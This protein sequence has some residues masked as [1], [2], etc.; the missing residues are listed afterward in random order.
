MARGVLG[1]QIGAL[2]DEVAKEVVTPEG[3]N[4]HRQR[5]DARGLRR[6]FRLGRD[7]LI[8]D[9]R[10]RVFDRPVK[11]RLQHSVNDLHVRAL[12][13]QHRRRARPI[14]DDRAHQRRL[15][16]RVGRIDIHALGGQQ[17]REHF[18]TP[19]L[20]GDMHHRLAGGVHAFHIR[21]VLEQ[22]FED[23]VAESRDRADRKRVPA[24]RLAVHVRLAREQH[25]HHVDAAIVRRHLERRARRAVERLHIRA[26]VEQHLDDLRPAVDHRLVQGGVALRILQIH[27][28][29]VLNQKLRAVGA[30]VNNHVVDRRVGRALGV[31]VRLGC[32]Q[33]LGRV[34]LA[35]IH[36]VLKRRVRRGIQRIHFRAL[37]RQV[38]DHV[39]PAIKRRVMQG[40]VLVR[41]VH[42]FNQLFIRVC[43]LDQLGQIARLGEFKNRRNLCLGPG[44]TNEK[45]H[46]RK[47]G[48]S[49]KKTNRPHHCGSF[50]N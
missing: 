47:K 15:A 37:L 1:G 43:Q 5:H 12:F 48:A 28:A 45:R 11:R 21:A 34:E 4:P 49:R 9:V 20:G 3:E 22:I 41:R 44:C 29:T 50:K 25:F 19:F 27:V 26:F 33:R 38:S 31:D 35:R 16:R 40:R 32:E 39:A 46:R 30:T 42:R 10:P 8:R 13:K 14:G 36:R 17:Q 23:V 6:H 7:Q 18:L 24:R 2:A